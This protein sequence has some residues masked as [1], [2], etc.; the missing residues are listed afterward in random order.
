MAEY[1]YKEDAAGKV[2]E[3]AGRIQEAGTRATEKAAGTLRKASESIRNVDVGAYRDQLADTIDNAK[4]DMDRK[5]D[6]VKTGIRDHPFESVAIAAGTGMLLG[7]FMAMMGRHAAR[8][9]A[10]KVERM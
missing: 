2:Q 4:T 3:T 8:H 5:V 6:D 10:R 7:A 9:A 1:T